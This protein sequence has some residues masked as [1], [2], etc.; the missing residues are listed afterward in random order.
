M[1]QIK[2]VIFDMD[3]TLLR[4]TIDFY[5]MKR[6]VF[7]HLVHH[8]IISQE[9]PFDQHTTSTILEHA[10]QS[11]LSEA[12]YTD[13]M[14]L[15]EKHELK[16]MEAAVLEPGAREVIESLYG[17]AAL[18]VITNN[19]AAAA[20]K[21][22]EAEGLRT[23]FDLIIGREQMTA[24]KPSPSGFHYAMRHFPHISTGE[25]ISIGDSWIDGKAAADAHIPF[26][27]YNAKEE[28]L[29]KRGIEPMGQVR[30]LT[31]FL[32]IVEAGGIHGS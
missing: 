21:A 12:L 15:V 20:V 7:E 26:V 25:W 6:E 22:M 10:K 23:F 32:N 1:G 18:V 5:S 17:R 13:L 9:Y 3:N 11:G 28:E 29:T 27:S 16:G 31:D 19:S 30:R 8:N 24:L 14:K 2:G 4:S